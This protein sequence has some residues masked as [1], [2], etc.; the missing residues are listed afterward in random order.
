MSTRACKEL[1]I[2]SDA[3]VGETDD[4]IQRVPEEFRERIPRMSLRPD[5]AL[6][7]EVGD[8]LIEDPPA[9]EL[10]DRVRRL[11]FR[12][13]PSLGTDLIVSTMASSSD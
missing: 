4:M 8:R 9:A 5:G 6:I 13:D 12:N 10:D 3:H 11:E 2:T 7:I 1:L